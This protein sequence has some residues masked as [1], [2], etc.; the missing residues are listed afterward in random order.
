VDATAL[1]RLSELQFKISY[2]QLIPTLFIIARP[3]KLFCL[4]LSE[5]MII[6]IFYSICHIAKFLYFL[7]KS[8]MRLGN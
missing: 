7:Q 2:C 5:F 1:I 6:Q 8:D 3:E 4:L